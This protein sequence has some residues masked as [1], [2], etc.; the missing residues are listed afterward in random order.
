MPQIPY[1]S[2]KILLIKGSG[3]G[4]TNTLINLISHLPDIDKIYL[5]AEVPYK[6]KYKLLINKRESVGLKHCNNSKFSFEYS[7]MVWVILI[8]TIEIK[9]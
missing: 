1:H 6:A 7:L 2:Y 9:N 3:S 8:N 5:Y 4:K